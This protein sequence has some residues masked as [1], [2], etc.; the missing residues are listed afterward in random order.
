MTLLRISLAVLMLLHGWAKVIHGVGGIEG[1]LTQMGLPAFF[2]YGVFV[3]EVVAPLLLLLGLYV[4]PAAW[5]IAINMLVA[6]GLAH[7]G[8]IFELGKSGGWAIE[9][10]AFFLINAIVVALGYSRKK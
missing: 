10:Q 8:Q 6:I 9:L 7:A 2:A 1:M 3:G 5:V 4:V